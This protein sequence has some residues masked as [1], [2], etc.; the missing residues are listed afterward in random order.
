MAKFF[1]TISKDKQSSLFGYELSLREQK[2][3]PYYLGE[4][5]K[6]YY[7]L[8]FADK[9]PTKLGRNKEM[10]ENDFYVIPNQTNPHF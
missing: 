7:A 5:E 3:R 10:K 6:K 4:D 9:K 1:G 2:C 8:Y